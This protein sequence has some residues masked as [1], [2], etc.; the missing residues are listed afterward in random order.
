MGAEQSRRRQQLL[1]DGALI[2]AWIISSLRFCDEKEIF[3]ILMLSS[4]FATFSRDDRFFKEISMNLRYRGVYVPAKLPLS[5]RSWKAFYMELHTTVWADSAPVPDPA[6]AES[7]GDLEVIRTIHSSQK[8]SSARFRVNVYARFRPLSEKQQQMQQPASKLPEGEEVECVLPLHQRLRMIKMS[9]AKT[10]REALR[11]LASEGD[12]FGQKW[13]AVQNSANAK[14]PSERDPNVLVEHESCLLKPK[15]Q[16]LTFIKSNSIKD[17]VVAKVQSADQATGRVI[18]IAPDVGVREFSFDGVVSSPAAGLAASNKQQEHCYS[19]MAKRL[20][21]DFIN[22]YNSTCIAYGQTASGKT[23]TMTGGA[24][25]CTPGIVPRAC[26]EVLTYLHDSLGMRAQLGIQATLSMS[27]IEIYGDMVCDLL[28]G[29]ERVGHSKVASQSFVLSGAME[30]SVQ[31][32]DDVYTALKTGDAQKR[33]AAT[34]MNDR[35]SRAHALV[36]LTLTQTRASTGVSRKS[37][38][39][40]ADLGGSEKAAKSKVEAGKS[41][42]T[43][44]AGEYLVGFE[45]DVRMR[46]AVNINLG[47]LALKRCIEALNLQSQA[48]YVPYQDSKLTMLLSQGLGGNCKTSIVV[49]AAMDPAHAVETMATMRFGE[50]CALVENDARNGASVL[51]SLLAELDVDIAATENAIVAKEKWVHKD[52]QRKDVNAEAGTFEAQG[53]GGMETKKVSYLTGAEAERRHLAAL[54][55]RR[56][57]F[58]GKAD[59][60]EE[61]QGKE[62]VPTA[63]AFGKSVAQEYGIGTAFDEAAD[64][65]ADNRRFHEALAKNELSAVVRMRGGKN[66]TSTKELEHDPK[67]LEEM[68]K[69]VKRSKL[70][71][72]GISA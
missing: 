70:V 27:Y 65:Q 15:D 59:E 63:M 39:F 4:K 54:L 17:R 30:T 64:A 7:E 48:T 25:G 58:T 62:N 57:A 12:W 41:R 33:R 6:A 50:R 45:K 47:L 66:W 37:R 61:G 43:G 52:V 60:A 29:G 53:M 71:Y 2:P 8:A 28:K 69:K 19:L 56:R 42:V 5:E 67:K 3:S 51:A 26:T 49:C 24:D 9:G 31:C 20:V 40:L 23:F 44:E 72:S 22:G 13:A 68:A 35:S 10:Q 1:P 34:A 18:V 14:G 38:L 32:L 11:T 16:P 55:A 46:E 21:V 36:I